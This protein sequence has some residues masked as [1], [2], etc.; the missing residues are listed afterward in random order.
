MADYA[1]IPGTKII[2]ANTEPYKCAELQRI[3]LEVAPFPAPAIT[4]IIDDN[5]FCLLRRHTQIV[6]DLSGIPDIGGAFEG[7]TVINVN[8]EPYRCDE[9]LRQTVVTA[10][11]PSPVVN[12]ER[13]DNIFC[14]VH[15]SEYIEA[16]PANSSW[17]RR[18][19]H[20][21]VCHWRIYTK[22]QMRPVRASDD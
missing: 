20:R 9:L 17:F 13:D 15:T 3:S 22:V 8:S 19:N 4:T 18:F 11:F 14:K 10:T 16:S 2:K 6:E 5:D 7:E 12:T 1:P 21:P